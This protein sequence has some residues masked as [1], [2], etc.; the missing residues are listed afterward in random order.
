MAIELAYGDSMSGKSTGLEAL[1]RHNFNQTGKGARVYLGDGGGDSYNSH[2]LVDDGVI[3]L[4]EYTYR[5][6][7]MTIVKL[8]GDLYFPKD[9][10]DPK[11]KLVAPPIDLFDKVGIIIFEGG[12]VMGQYLLN[13]PEGSMEWQAAQQ[14]GFGGVK[15][16]A[17]ELHVTDGSEYKEYNEQGSTTSKHYAIIQRRILSCIRASKKFPGLVYWTSHPTEGPDR[18]EGGESK[19]FGDIVGKKVIGPD[20]GGRAPVSLISKEF[21]NTLHFD[22]VTIQ[23]REA[24]ETSKKQV[25]T[26]NKEYRVYTRRHYDPNGQVNIEYVAGNRGAVPKMIEDYYVSKEPG[27]ALLQFYE[28]MSKAQQSIKGVR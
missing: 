4:M 7:P 6:W 28:A 20:F 24:D 15:D 12:T 22:N 18:T 17:D 19:G 1:I 8:M 14:T 2:G 10:T 13:G 26:I 27:D 5:E 3:Q 23:K 21:G 25:T 16:A 9:P 11:S